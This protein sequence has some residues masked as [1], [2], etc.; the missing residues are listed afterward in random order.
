MKDVNAIIVGAGMAGLASAIKCQENGLEY[1]IIERSSRVGGKVGSIY[2]DDFIFDLG[3]QVYNTAYSITNSILDLNDINLKQFK[4]G[5]MIH[6]KE[7]SCIIAD[8]IRD[9]RYLFSTIFSGITT[10]SDKI[11]ILSLKRSLR[12]YTI[13]N[14]T[15]P[16]QQTKTFLEEFGFSEKIIEF[17]FRPFFAGIFLE[18]KLKTSAKFFKF[19]FSKFNSGLAT[20]PEYGMQA[21]PNS[22]V[23][24]ISPDK[25]LLNNEVIGLKNN[26]ISLKN[27][28]TIS[29]DY[30]ILTGHSRSLGSYRNAEYNFVKTLY[31]S[32]TD[33]PPNGKY[34]HL[35]PEDDLMNN[36]AFP[37]IISEH[38]AKNDVHL[39]SVTVISNKLKK[40]ELIKNI[41]QRLSKYFKNE[42]KC[43]RFLE[44]MDIKEAT[45]K[46]SPKFFE[47]KNIFNDGIVYAG[48]YTRNG[49]IEGAVDSG[50]R[51]VAAIKNQM[52]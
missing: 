51:A 25:I 23:K 28:Q 31:F 27:G 41:E 38:Y 19:I 13:E 46:Q 20:L 15:E 26:I 17:F 21:I 37:S 6:L 32:S 5:A 44:Y 40:T 52:E 36:V 1:I 12:G 3:F 22:I 33:E 11:K 29:A 42:E 30:F 8:P 34:I 45:I 50:I 39:L 2:K 24:N 49:S 4:P 14:D 43:Y 35:F 47:S 48:D 9:M 7:K 16:D 18:K 10:F